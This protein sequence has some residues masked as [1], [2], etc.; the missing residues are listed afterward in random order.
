ME[1]MTAVNYK[2]PLTIV[3]FN[4]QTMGLIR[5][6]QHQLYDQRFIN[7]DFVNPDFALLANAFGITHRKIE[8]IPQC[9][10]LFEQLDVQHDINLIE[11]MLDQ[12]AYPNYSS[13]R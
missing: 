3:V 12:D 11:V 5:K 4:N 10:S 7:C 9:E 6:N 13:R 2:I 1:I 8:T